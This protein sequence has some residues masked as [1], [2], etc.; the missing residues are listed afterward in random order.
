VIRELRRRHRDF[1]FSVSVT[2]RARRKGERHGTHYSFLSHD[3]FARLRTQKKLA[4]WASVHDQFY[5]TPKANLKQA[6][7]KRRVMLCDLDVQG[8]AALRRADR[9]VVTIFLVP[10]SWA[11][12]RKRLL[13]RGSETTAQFR[14][15]L[16]TA[17]LEMKRISDYEYVVTND[18][19]EQCVSDCEAIIRAEI[20]RQHLAR[21]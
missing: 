19:L 13:G 16:Q 9:S 2:T 1:L 12:L 14:R 15:R 4:E 20:L 8:A 17:R 5:G 21:K 7:R 10:P 6:Y 11:V 18:R 3:Q